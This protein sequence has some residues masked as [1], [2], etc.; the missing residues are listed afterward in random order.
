MPFLWA[1]ALSKIPSHLKKKTLLKGI[2]DVIPFF[3]DHTGAIQFR[4]L[5]DLV[6]LEATA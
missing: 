3:H 1:F 5:K 6:N 2:D 4:L